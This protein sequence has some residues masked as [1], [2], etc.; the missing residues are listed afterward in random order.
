MNLV[1]THT[2]LYLEEFDDDRT[3]VMERARAAGITHLFM[4]NIDRST[5]E[6]MLRLCADYPGYAFPMMGLHPTSVGPDY[7]DELD[8]VHRYL[9]SPPIDADRRPHIVAVGEIGIDLYWDRTYERE[10]TEVFARQVEWA[11]QLDLPIVIH[12]RNAFDAVYSVLQPYRDTPLSGIF[13]SFTGNA[14][15]VDRMLEFKRFRIG[16]NGVVTFKRSTLPE[17][18]PRIPLDRIVLETDSPYLTPVPY[19]GRRNESAHI[20]HTA[21]RVAEAYRLSVDEVAGTTSAN[22]LNL[23][24]GAK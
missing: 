22:A 18:L 10:Q 14:D 3:A 23:F 1:D 9:F 5:V 16:I 8:A 17:L 4:P 21:A 15:E 24:F 20:V 11:L 7:R 13:H 2:H 19:R 12:C 6:P